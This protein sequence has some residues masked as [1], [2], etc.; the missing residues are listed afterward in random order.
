MI[1]YKKI[2]G[3]KI[4]LGSPWNFLGIE[5][6]ECSAA[7][8]SLIVGF[9]GNVYPCDAMKYFDYLGSGGNIYH[10]SLKTAFLTV[11]FSESIA[12]LGEVTCAFLYYGAI[13]LFHVSIE[14]DT[15]GSNLFNLFVPLF[16]VLLI[17]FPFIKVVF[18]FMTD[19]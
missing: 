7:E 10:N 9:D 4:R 19:K 5:K 8:K 11:V 17:H 6:T 2:Y 15:G 13:E 12:I 16:S 1:E 18:N 14:L 3:G